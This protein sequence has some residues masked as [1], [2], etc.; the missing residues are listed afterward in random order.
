[1]K[2]MTNPDGS[3]TWI[4]DPGFDLSVLDEPSGTYVSRRK[5]AWI[6]ADGG[7]NAWEEVP[8]LFPEDAEPEPAEETPEQK[9]A[10]LTAEIEAL[11]AMTQ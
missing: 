10:R 6:P 1:M 8:E 5:E 9:I 4:A 11:K 2:K 7:L 3:A